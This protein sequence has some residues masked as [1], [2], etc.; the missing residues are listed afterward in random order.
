MSVK[1]ASDDYGGFR[2]LTIQ[3]I[4]LE[5]SFFLFCFSISEFL[6]AVLKRAPIFSNNLVTLFT[7]V[8]SKLIEVP[9]WQV[10]KNFFASKTLS[11]LLFLTYSELDPV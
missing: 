2:F 1:A 10:S 8:L 3:S 7:V 5:P 6:A 9:F 11:N 4:Q